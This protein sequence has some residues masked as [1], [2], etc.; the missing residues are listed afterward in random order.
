M[1]L[2]EGVALLWTVLRADEGVRTS[3]MCRKYI[4]SM[5]GLGLVGEGFQR[6][7]PVAGAGVLRSCVG[8]RGRT[9]V[10]ALHK[11]AWLQMFIA[12]H[13][14]AGGGSIMGGVVRF[15]C[16]CRLCDDGAMFQRNTMDHG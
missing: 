1:S 2:A 6:L 16:P 15:A 14:A 9:Q 13:A 12:Q 4:V 8:C 11:A 10:H 5:P 7:L 3:C